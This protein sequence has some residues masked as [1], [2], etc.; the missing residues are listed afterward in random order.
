MMVGHKIEE[1][2]DSSLDR[3][4]HIR[5]DI[6]SVYSDETNCAHCDHQDDGQHHRVLGHLLPVFVTAN[7][8]NIAE[9][10]YSPGAP[11]PS[12]PALVAVG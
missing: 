6:A 7:Y 1:I 8:P 5:K 3:A 12:R 10:R 9:Q 2:A 11:K 4:A